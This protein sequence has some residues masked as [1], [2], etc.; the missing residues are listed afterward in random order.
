MINLKLNYCLIRVDTIEKR[1]EPSEKLFLQPRNKR[2]LLDWW[3]EV[4]SCLTLISIRERSKA[5]SF[6]TE[7]L[8]LSHFCEWTAEVLRKNFKKLAKGINCQSG[9]LTLFTFQRCNSLLAQCI[10][11]WRSKDWIL[12]FSCNSYSFLW[13]LWFFLTENVTI[14]FYICIW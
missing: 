5:P 10:A 14:F 2:V 6:K 3:G 1:L 11:L 13:L 4:M 8:L 12:A 7:E 9:K